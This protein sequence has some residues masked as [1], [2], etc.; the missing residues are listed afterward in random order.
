MTKLVTLT[1]VGL[2]FNPTNTII[3]A[4]LSTYPMQKTIGRFA[5][6]PTGHLHFGSLIA[7][8]ASYCM[9]K[10]AGGKWL[11]RIEDLDRPRVVAGAADTILHQLESF[12]LIWD[13]EVIYQRDRSEIYR[14]AIESLK[15]AGSTYQ[16]SCSR[17]EI[18]ASA[19]HYGE[20]GPIYPG[21]C[22]NK[23]QTSSSSCCTRII[24]S[25]N[26]I[27]FTDGIY[28]SLSQ[29]L[30]KEVGDFPLQR[31]DGIFSYQLAV[32]VDDHEFGINQV[33]RGRDLLF[34]TPR[35]IYL[36]Q[37]LGYA[38]PTYT[39]IPLALS[40]NGEKIS[41]R[42]HQVDNSSEQSPSVLL[43]QAL[44]FLGQQPPK[45]LRSE[46]PTTI[47]DWACSHFKLQHIAPADR[48]FPLSKTTP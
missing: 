45:A 6:S 23:S 28:G 47:V 19:P 33:V 21:T 31:A 14:A 10:Q 8:I 18:L 2:T 17:R 44:D 24:I 32:A 4:M 35:Q 16:C 9:A 11:V 3:P 25:D 26:E 13:G 38:I 42:H 39:H 7:A 43:Y 41:K 40:P 20:E 12:G 34:S 37:Q 1:H 29:N 5:P 22:R 27:K 46:V 36:L 30:A 15:L 48:L